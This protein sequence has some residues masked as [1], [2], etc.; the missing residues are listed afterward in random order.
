M[1]EHVVHLAREAAALGRHRRTRLRLARAPQRVALV[2]ELAHQAHHQEPR[3]RGEQHRHHFAAAA[4]D[5][6]HGD[7]QRQRARERQRAGPAFE[8]QRRDDPDEHRARLPRAVRLQHR[9]RGGGGA[10]GEQRSDAAPNGR[11]PVRGLRGERGG[12]QR[13]RHEHDHSAAALES[14]MRRRG[15][16]AEHEHHEVDRHE[17]AKHDGLERSTPVADAEPAPTDPARGE[18]SVEQAHHHQQTISR[19]RPAVIGCWADSSCEDLHP[20]VEHKIRPVRR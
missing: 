7:E 3:H 11:V 14:R 5:R 15:Q 12:D 6:Q 2:G 13:D 4:V 18:P 8:P 10:H 19:S 1:R 20:W 16:R 9:E 17:V